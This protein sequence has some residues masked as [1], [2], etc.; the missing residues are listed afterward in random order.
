MNVRTTKA[1]SDRRGVG[2]KIELE[3][4]HDGHAGR[5]GSSSSS[6]SSQLL[7]RA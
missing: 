1:C 5:N 3:Y 7:S 4:I 6:S 2:P